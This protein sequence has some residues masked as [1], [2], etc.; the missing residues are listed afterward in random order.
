M[1]PRLSRIRA[2]NG[3]QDPDWECPVD[4]AT[5][6]RSMGTV[7]RIMC[8]Q[9]RWETVASRFRWCYSLRV[10]VRKARVATKQ[11]HWIKG[12]KDHV[13]VVKDTERGT[14]SNAPGMVAV[15]RERLKSK[16]VG[17]WT[18]ETMEGFHRK[19]HFSLWSRRKER[20]D[21]V[22]T[23]RCVCGRAGLWGTS[24][25]AVSNNSMKKGAC[26]VP[27]EREQA[28]RW[29]LGSLCDF[30]P[31][32]CTQWSE[33]ESRHGERWIIQDWGFA[34]WVQKVNRYFLRAQ[35]EEGRGRP[36]SK[37]LICPKLIL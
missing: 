37:R 36:S 34:R 35:G 17:G 29:R 14:C 30:P 31:S 4:L 1:L 10:K 8:W 22:I 27:A 26:R 25:L 28:N 32:I 12:S 16:D 9:G 23:V 5:W 33:A 7:D 11:W 19:R 2:G 15:E 18:P 21:D 13:I 24:C 6:R 20:A 3:K